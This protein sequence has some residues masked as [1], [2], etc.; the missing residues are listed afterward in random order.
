MLLSRWLVESR[1]ILSFG[2]DAHADHWSDPATSIGELDPPTRNT[3]LYIG[4]IAEVRRG[5]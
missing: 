5:L 2:I 3:T 1:T 4:A